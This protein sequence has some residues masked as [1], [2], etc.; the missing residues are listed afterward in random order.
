M[1]C[2]SDSIGNANYYMKTM[3]DVMLKNGMLIISTC[4][5]NVFY[6]FFIEEIILI[7]RRLCILGQNIFN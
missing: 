3:V 1:K 5:I 2:T 6:V 4:T 7:Y